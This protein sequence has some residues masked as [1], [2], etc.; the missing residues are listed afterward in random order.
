MEGET[1]ARE[2]SPDRAEETPAG[3][4][5]KEA[6]DGYFLPSLVSLFSPLPSSLLFSV[7]SPSCLLAFSLPEFAILNFISS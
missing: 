3:L 4:C 1:E 6:Q 5:N 2:G 7:F